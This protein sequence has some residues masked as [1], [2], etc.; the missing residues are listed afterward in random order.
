[1]KKARDRSRG[2]EYGKFIRPMLRTEILFP[3]EIGPFLNPIEIAEAA[4]PGGPLIEEA[5]VGGIQLARNAGGPVSGR[6]SGLDRSRGRR[7]SGSAITIWRVAAPK[8]VLKLAVTC[9]SNVFAAAGDVLKPLFQE[10]KPLA[11][12]SPL[13]MFG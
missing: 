13:V 6:R 1:M 4:D 7:S 2:Q 12:K 3:S 8:K 10:S 5:V 11:L 9:P